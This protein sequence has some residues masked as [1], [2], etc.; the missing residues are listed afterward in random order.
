MVDLWLFKDD[1][2]SILGSKYE[3]RYVMGGNTSGI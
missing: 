3:I 1:E 2:D